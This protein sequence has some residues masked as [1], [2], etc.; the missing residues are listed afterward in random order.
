MMWTNSSK[1]SPPSVPWMSG[2]RFLDTMWTGEAGNGYA[3]KSRPP[4]RYVWGFTCGLSKVR[5]VTGKKLRLRSRRVTA[6]ALALRVDDVAAQADERILPFEIEF[7]RRDLESP[8]H[9]RFVPLLHA[10]VCCPT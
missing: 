5:I 4:P 8:A 10:I 1:L 7:D 3:P 2:V 6:I 9:L